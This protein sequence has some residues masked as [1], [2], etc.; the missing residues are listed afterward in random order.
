MT[1][2]RP[3]TWETEAG[4]TGSQDNLW[5]HKDFRVSPILSQKKKK[6][7]GKIDQWLRTLVALTEDLSFVP[8]IHTSHNHP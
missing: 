8:I 7:A 5:F 2:H 1:G 3:G 4:E 6:Q